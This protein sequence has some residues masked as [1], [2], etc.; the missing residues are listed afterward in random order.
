MGSI[1]EK[2]IEQ[3]NYEE[4]MRDDEEIV[5]FIPAGLLYDYWRLFGGIFLQRENKREKIVEITYS[6]NHYTHRANI[7]I[8]SM[9]IDNI[10]KIMKCGLETGI[11]LFVSPLQKA[12]PIM[13]RADVEKQSSNIEIEVKEMATETMRI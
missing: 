1:R 10:I 7:D 2:L 12:E 8:T 13:W 6:N 3:I 11:D 5:N 4:I 9:A